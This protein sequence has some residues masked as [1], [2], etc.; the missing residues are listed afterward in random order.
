MLDQAILARPS[1]L[2]HYLPEVPYRYAMGLAGSLMLGWT[3]LLLWA[4]R[5]PAER[6]GVLMITNFVIRRG[7]HM[8]AA[9]RLR[10]EPPY[11]H[12]PHLPL[13]D[14]RLGLQCSEQVETRGGRGSH[15]RAAV[16][17]LKG[18]HASRN[19]CRSVPVRQHLRQLADRGDD[20][21]GACEVMCVG[22]EMV[23]YDDALD[24]G[25]PRGLQPLLGVFHDDRLT[26]S[27]AEAPQGGK[28]GF[29]RWLFFFVIFDRE[30]ELHVF[31]DGA[32]SMNEIEIGSFRSRDDG[33]FIAI[34]E[35][36]EHLLNPRYR[37]LL[38]TEELLIV[39][40]P[41]RSVLRDD[42]FGDSGLPGQFP[43]RLTA[44]SEFVVVGSLEIHPDF[45]KRAP[46][47]VEVPLLGVNQH[48]V[49]IP[50]NILRLRHRPPG[51]LADHLTQLMSVPGGRCGVKIEMYC[52]FSARARVS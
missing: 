7:V 4:D 22:E 34:L 45:G 44:G 35:E 36:R 10:I 31:H 13:G 23:P 11:F 40:V 52:K 14:W 16:A 9:A 43:R 18:L 20:V 3:I 39:C 41:V 25:G 37:D 48:A 1:P 17:G 21:P 28:I 27:N 8:R 50:E 6:R 12:D 26:R 42:R 49:M 38:S 46:R 51:C 24:A 29:R 32:R 5:R 15:G 2:T 33:H 47:G 19:R 30:Y